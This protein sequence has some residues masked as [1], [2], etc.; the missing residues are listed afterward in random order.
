MMTNE[1]AFIRLTMRRDYRT[2]EFPHPS[3]YPPTALE[4]F[5]SLDVR[6]P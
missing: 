5:S 6:F 1:G 3:A 2:Y 4:V